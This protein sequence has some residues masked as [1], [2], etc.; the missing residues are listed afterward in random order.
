LTD[1]AARRKQADVQLKMHGLNYEFL[2]AVQKKE[3][4]IAQIQSCDKSQFILNTGREPTKGE[5]ACFASHK[6][7]WKL[8]VTCMH[9]I[10]IMEDDFLLLNGFK[11]SLSTAEKHI[12]KLGYIR[13]QTET[14]AK[15]NK[16]L[17]DGEF[18]MWRYT[19]APHSMACY[20]VSPQAASILLEASKRMIAPSDVYLKM[21]WLHGQLIYGLSPYTV[22]I[23]E[24]H[25]D[26]HIGERKKTCKNLTMRFTRL[27]HKT[28]LLFIR[29]FTNLAISANNPNKI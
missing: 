28:K 2:N 4:T 10:V 1:A 22:A 19:K 23:S 11:Q 17:V 24:L 8:C 20:V 7:A 6:K 13:L 16:L 21:F 3:L 14:R 26:S 5:I 18:T 12:E 29:F 15:K 9:P 27:R 25:A